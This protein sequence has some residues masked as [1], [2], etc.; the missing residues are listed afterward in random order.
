MWHLEK[1][2]TGSLVTFLV[3]GS[4][5]VGLRDATPLLKS[6]GSSMVED[7]L[8]LSHWIWIFIKGGRTVFESAVVGSGTPISGHLELSTISS[9]VN[10]FSSNLRKKHWE[11]C[12]N[13]DVLGN[14]CDAKSGYDE[15]I[16]LRGSLSHSSSVLDSIPVIIVGGSRVAYLY[17][18]LKSVLESPGVKKDNIEVM[19]GDTTEDVVMLLQL[20]NIKYTKL[21]TRGEGNSKLFQLYRSV[22]ETVA[23]KYSDSPAAIF[24]D[25]DVE[26]APDF[27]SLMDQ[28]VPLLFEDASL[29]CVSGHAFATGAKF[30]GKLDMVKRLS[31]PPQW[32]YALKREFILE[33]LSKWSLSEKN[34][35]IYDFWL[36]LEVAEER[37]C[38]VPEVSR[39]RHFGTGQND[40]AEH[41]EKIFLNVQLPQKHGIRI[42]NL[43]D[44][45]RRT[46]T[47]ITLQN[48]QTAKVL[49]GNPCDIDIS[50]ELVEGNY[51]FYYLLQ[52]NQEDTLE[53]AS[54]FSVGECF[55]F[56]ALADFGWH[57]MV[58]KLRLKGSVV[59]YVVGVPASPYTKYLKVNPGNVFNAKNLTRDEQRK[60][61]A[62]SNAFQ[63]NI[64]R[65]LEMKFFGG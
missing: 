44:L 11:L 19:L 6:F 40:K 13:V 26:V 33:A 56:W 46:W 16:R 48:L 10:S 4:G 17:H 35:I 34:S 25:E 63:T 29:F 3:A 53:L 14:F 12:Q 15:L 24:M 59:L 20:L 37:E 32:G 43:K 27:F 55:G 21:Q 22:F 31:T 51:V 36:L 28:L 58:T 1:I 54:Y 45:R 42:R 30:N 41:L 5:A 8:P 60:V 49:H 2:R 62:K 64:I 57:E 38:V 7:L 47:N 9:K 52:Y 50:T 23:V 65:G 39:T 18:S 61:N